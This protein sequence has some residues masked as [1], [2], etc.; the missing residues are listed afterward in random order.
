MVDPTPDTPSSSSSKNDK[1]V[2]SSSLNKKILYKNDPN[3]A[4]KETESSK[5]VKC[6]K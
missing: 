6:Q 2:N 5:K 1:T 3:S 4:A